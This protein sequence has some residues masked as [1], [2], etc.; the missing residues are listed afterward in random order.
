MTRHGQDACFICQREYGT[1]TRHEITVSDHEQV[2]VDADCEQAITNRARAY[3]VSRWEATQMVMARITETMLG[4][5]RTSAGE[6]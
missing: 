2:Y 3:N 4:A 1:G 5:P 6:E